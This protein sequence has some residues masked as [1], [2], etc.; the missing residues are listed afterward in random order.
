V[1]EGAEGGEVGGGAG[2]GDEEFEEAAVVV[3]F[4]EGDVGGV[5]VVGVVQDVVGVGVFDGEVLGVGVV[6]PGDHLGE[7]D[8]AVFG[9]GECDEGVVGVVGREFDL[10]DVVPVLCG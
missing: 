10:D 8:D 6:A 5:G 4:D 1:G 9:V 3:G 7:V 2:V